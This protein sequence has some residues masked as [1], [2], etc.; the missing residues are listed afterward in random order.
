ML[1]NENDVW[2]ELHK[3]LSSQ[4]ETTRLEI[5]DQEFPDCTCAGFWEMIVH[6]PVLFY[7][8]TFPAC[9]ALAGDLLFSRVRFKN[10]VSFQNCTFRSKLLRFDQCTFEGEL[11]FFH[12]KSMPEIVFLESSTLRGCLGIRECR[13]D[14]LHVL[15]GN[16]GGKPVFEKPVGIED[17]SFDELA[18]HGADCR[19][20][21]HI[22]NSSFGKKLSFSGS[23]FAGWIH[24]KDVI[25]NA[26]PP[27]AP[28]QFPDG[29]DISSCTLVLQRHLVHYATA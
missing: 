29:L 3:A 20:G 9:E 12:C 25:V 5:K 27:R 10:G 26:S 21:W 2:S 18:V 28:G 15:S 23:T 22:S 14:R 17:S 19:L 11:R 24:M 1:G 6:R 4:E 13:F 16:S 8:V 7:G